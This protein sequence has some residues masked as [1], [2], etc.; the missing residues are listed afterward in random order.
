MLVHADGSPCREGTQSVPDDYIPCCKLFEAHTR[1][2]VY[3]IRYEW[4]PKPDK[5]VIAI[6]EAAGGGGITISFCP[7]C[8]AQLS[9]SG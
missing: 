5:W 9:P 4:W 3:D 7:H 2:C 1:T 6:S 8:G